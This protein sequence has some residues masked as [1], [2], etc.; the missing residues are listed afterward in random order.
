MQVVISL[1][2]FK[3]LELRIVNYTDMTLDESRKIWEVRNLPAI[4]KYMTQPEP[5][6]FESHQNFVESLRNN[7]SKIPIMP[8][9]VMTNSWVLTISLVSKMVIQPN[10][11]C[12][13][14]LLFMARDMV[15]SLSL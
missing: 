15:Q 6:P 5:F 13:S 11:V 2:A 7:T 3:A 14:I 12:T 1:N 10:M 4:R 8:S 9:F